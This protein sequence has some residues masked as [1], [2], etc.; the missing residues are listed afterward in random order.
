MFWIHL[1]LGGIVVLLGFTIGWLDSLFYLLGISIVYFFSLLKRNL[2]YKKYLRGSFF[3][4]SFMGLLA[5]Y[6]YEIFCGNSFA[7]YNDDSFY[8]RNINEILNYG[9]SE[10]ATIYEYIVAIL[11]LPF[12][13]L[14]LHEHFSLLVINWIVASLTVIEAL[15]F[16][17]NLYPDKE[18]ATNA[19]GTCLIM[20]NSNYING[21]V[22]LYRDIWMCYFFILSLNFA[23]NKKIFNASVCVILTGFIR[24]ANGFWALLIVLVFAFANFFSRLSKKLIVLIGCISLLLFLGLDSVV[25]FSSYMRSF[26]GN[27]AK[28]SLAERISERKEAFYEDGAEVGGVLS[29]MQ[30]SNPI[31][32]AL[33]VPI[34]MVSPIRVG[35]YV[36]A[37]DYKTEE[38][39]TYTVFRL[40]IEFIWEL[41]SVAFMAWS[42]YYL[43]M[44]LFYM[45]KDDNQ[46][47]F[48]LAILF[49]LMVAVIAFISMQHRHKMMFILF[50]PLLYRSYKYNV[51]HSGYKIINE[52]PF[53]MMSFLIILIYNVFL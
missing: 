28:I 41:L 47:K 12:K 15:K 34:Y 24:G 45:L 35:D 2:K 1:L 18:L 23:W 19:I 33:V 53:I 37:E 48:I 46:I 49:I 13:T 7:P 26:S 17:H 22:H 40:R 31:L 8:F 16:A 27:Q 42:M 4:F 5:F 51:K 36:V 9:Y 43:F 32:K 10:L 50:F 44:G 20:L 6:S 30:S 29:L 11:I 21:S 14:G 52:N 39:R 25:G 3:Y 38:S